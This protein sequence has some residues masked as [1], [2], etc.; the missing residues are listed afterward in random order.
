MADTRD[1]GPQSKPTP[2]VYVPQWQV[3]DDINRY[4]NGVFQWSIIMRAPHSASLL[5]PVEAAVHSFDPDQPVVRVIP[6]EQIAANWVASPRLIT[7]VMLLFAA[8]ALLMTAVGLYGLLSYNVAE[9]SREIGVR[10]ALGAASADVLRLVLREGL[11]LGGLGAIAGLAAAYFA[12]G[13]IATQL[14]SVRPRDPLAFAVAAAFVL[15]I[16]L[17][18]STLPARRAAKIDPMVAL[19]CE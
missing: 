14:F 2:V 4:Q 15:L 18:A 7:Q 8:M 13:L 17:L 19:R 1:F 6:L 9:R 12:A 16:T 11:L 5:A 3:P 10:K